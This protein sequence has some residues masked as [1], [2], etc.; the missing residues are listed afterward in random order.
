MEQYSSGTDRM[1]IYFSGTKPSFSSFWIDG[2]DFGPS[3][4]WTSNGTTS[5]RKDLSNNPFTNSSNQW[6]NGATFVID[7]SY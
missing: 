4:A 1:Y 6:V 2:F 7:A 3:S 5:W